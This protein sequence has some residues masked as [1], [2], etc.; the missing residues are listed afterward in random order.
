MA[1]IEEAREDLAYQVIDPARVPIARF[2]P[3]RRE[4]VMVSF[5]TSLFFAIFLVF[6]LDYVSKMKRSAKSTS[7]CDGLHSKPINNDGLS[8]HNN[9]FISK[10]QEI[11]ARKFRRKSV[12]SE[13]VVGKNSKN[14]T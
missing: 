9:Q 6:F 5:M 2:K 4:I 3:K 13:H 8:K 1:K 14:P 11:L 10:A 7:F 12:N